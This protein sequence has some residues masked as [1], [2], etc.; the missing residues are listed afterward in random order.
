[1][2]LTYEQVVDAARNRFSDVDVS[3]VAGTRAFQINIEGK[4]A[5]GIFY[6]EIKDGNVN[7]EPYEYYDRNAIFK[8]SAK[9]F[10][11]LLDGKLDP[12]AA[13]TI[14]KIKVEGDINAALE[15]IKFLK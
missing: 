14:G 5:N 1:M 15:M 8:M 3:S 13:F 6:I 9:N 4:E 11:K 12:I 2:A 10:I 7:V